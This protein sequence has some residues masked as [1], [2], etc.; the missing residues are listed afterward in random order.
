MNDF[1]YYNPVRVHF[2]ADAMSCLPEELGKFGP[3]V[4]LTYGGGSIRRTGL[5]LAFKKMPGSFWRTVFRSENAPTS[6]NSSPF[7][8][9]YQSTT[10]SMVF[11]Q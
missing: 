10:C 4:L 6:A 2:G 9:E 1:M 8:L 11:P 3:K 7:N 5:Y